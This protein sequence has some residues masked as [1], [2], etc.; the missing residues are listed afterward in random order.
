MTKKAADSLILASA[1]WIVLGI[2]LVVG[3]GRMGQ[4]AKAF[5][6][7]TLPLCAALTLLTIF[8]MVRDFTRNQ[9]KIEAIAALAL[10]APFAYYLFFHRW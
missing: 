4:I 2:G 10:V 1:N 7:A 3:S 6:V 9:K 5:A 8:F